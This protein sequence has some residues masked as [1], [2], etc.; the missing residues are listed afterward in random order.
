[1]NDVVG[2]EPRLHVPQSAPVLGAPK[3]GEASRRLE[4]LL[5]FSQL[6][7]P[8]QWSKSNG[9]R[10]AP[11][12]AFDIE[13][14]N[15]LLAEL[16][17]SLTNEQVKTGT[18][19]IRINDA[20][21]AEAAKKLQE[22]MRIAHEKAE[23]AKKAASEGNVAG[24]C[25]A[26]FGMIGAMVGVVAAA[27]GTG[28]A[29]VPLAVAGCILAAQDIANMAIKES[30]V[31]WDQHG[32][33]KKLDISFGGLVDMAVDETV[34]GLGLA[35]SQDELR[36]IKKGL[37]IGLTVSIALTMMIGG[38]AGL[39][40]TGKAAEA[41]SSAAKLSETSV[42]VERAAHGSGI[43]MDAA[44][45]SSSIAHSVISLEV[46][47]LE[48]DSDRARAQ[49]AFLD[50]VLQDIAKRIGLAQDAIRELVARFNENYDRMSATI[51]GINTN[52]ETSARNM[53]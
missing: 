21:R 51:A 11:P 53:G 19:S 52:L 4:A 36:E 16:D 29:L 31:E 37:T 24:W 27:A 8:A 6:P 32:Q 38:G 45:A 39:A 28:G 44:Q 30:D 46:A 33:T 49:K 7:P 10:L 25:T 1:M 14:L 35:V 9:P 15:A 12:K 18:E 2:R 47:G 20:E 5:S 50:A 43:V 17:T 13:S 42:S 34:H 41:A 22:Q 26:V 3:A 48:R 40:R 23:A